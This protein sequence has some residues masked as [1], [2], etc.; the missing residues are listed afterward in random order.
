MSLVGKWY[1]IFQ[2]YEVFETI[3][4]S[5]V[6]FNG[7]F[8]AVHDL[9][10]I[11]SWQERPH[12]GILPTPT[13]GWGSTDHAVISQM[14]FKLVAFPLVPCFYELCHAAHRQTLI[15]Q[16]K[17]EKLELVELRLASWPSGVH[18]CDKHVAL[19]SQQLYT[20]DR[21]CTLAGLLT[22]YYTHSHTLFVPQ[23]L[24]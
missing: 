4:F 8:M 7:V 1:R 13:L 3:L 6:S 16:M 18:S 5:K 24:R 20:P 23:L 10:R 14:F 21:R 19:A 9:L 15:E 17:R 22:R 12:T 2:L 11:E